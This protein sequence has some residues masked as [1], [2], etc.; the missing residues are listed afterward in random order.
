[1][2]STQFSNGKLNH[3]SKYRNWGLLLLCI[4]IMLV[5]GCKRDKDVDQEAPDKFNVL[6]VSID[7]LR[8]QL[9]CYG[10]NVV[11]S[12][13]LDAFAKDAAIF[14]RAYCQQAL[15]SASRA[16]ILTGLRP[17]TTGNTGMYLKGKPLDEQYP[18]SY[19]LP[20]S[21]KDSDYFS[22]SIGKVF[23]QMGAT[24]IGSDNV[25][26]AWSVPAWNPKVGAY[27]PKGMQRF[28]EKYD[29]L[30]SAGE[31]M[32]KISSIPRVTYIEAPNVPD[33][34]LP[35]GAM[36][37]KAVEVIRECKKNNQ[38]FFLALGFVKPH[39]PFVAPKKYWD[40]YN[41]DSLKLPPNRFHPL[42]VPEYTLLKD[43]G[44]YKYEN[45]P[46]KGIQPSQ[47]QAINALHGYLACISYV[48]A[49]FQKV[50]QELKNQNLYDNTI[51]VVYGD[52]G[53]QIGEHNAWGTKHSNYES[54]T[55]VPLF[56][57]VPNAP[58]NGKSSNK[59][60][61][62]LDIYPTLVDYCNLNK[63]QYKLE[64]MSLRP[65]I[66]SDPN[67]RW[68][69]EA[70]SIYPRNIPGI[71]AV[72]GYSMVTDT[73]RLVKWTAP[74]HNF[75]E[76]ELYDHRIDSQENFNLAEVPYYKSTLDR[77]K[78]FMEYEDEFNKQQLVD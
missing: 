66:E 27:G 32:R 56:I 29:S 41:S 45:G 64:G 62:L 75:T 15:C 50:I 71:G 22:F 68:K 23:H 72:M 28:Q 36:A 69:K 51:V 20:E 65:I 24:S 26:D 9:G 43:I 21:F 53:Y 3:S 63:P 46:M 76:Y 25:T 40:L 58:M 19:T 11:K 57:R 13:Y 49:Q 78:R 55:R 10:D 73:F 38:N 77:L 35:D 42:G 16:S 74:G 1:M 14:T 61:E 59:L 18:A 30:A 67:L 17:E 34:Q 8:P 5:V 48:D 6:F 60:V 33:D 7:D 2:K 37:N 47:K 52:H 31:D 4:I 44:I 54:S 39:L 70:F 12:P